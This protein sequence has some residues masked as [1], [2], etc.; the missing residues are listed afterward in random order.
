MI[1]NCKKFL[2]KKKSSILK[3][4][5]ANVNVSMLKQM[6]KQKGIEELFSFD[7]HGVIVSFDKDLINLQN[8]NMKIC[9]PNLMKDLG[10]TIIDSLYAESVKPFYVKD[11]TKLA[12]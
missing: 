3:F 12:C 2:C 7:G 11:Q 4:F 5:D 10:F 8:S 6:L 1:F 9:S